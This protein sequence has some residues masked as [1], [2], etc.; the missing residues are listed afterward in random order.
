MLSSC[1]WCGR[2]CLVA[3]SGVVITLLTRNLTTLSLCDSFTL[4]LRS[5]LCQLS[6]YINT[7]LAGYIITLLP[8]YLH[9]Y[10]YMKT[11]QVTNSDF[12]I[13]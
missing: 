2:Q 3:V 13:D 9:K 8:G 5:V 11:L 4:L 1:W 10:N 6:W 12:I 7:L